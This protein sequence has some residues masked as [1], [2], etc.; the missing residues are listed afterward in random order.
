MIRHRRFAPA[1][2]HG[3]DSNKEKYDR[4]DGENLEQHGDLPCRSV[5]MVPQG[6]RLCSDNGHVH[7]N[8][9]F[10]VPVTQRRA[11]FISRSL[12][13]STLQD[14]QSWILR[15]TRIGSRA[16]AHIEN[17]APIGVNFAHEYTT[18]A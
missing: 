11:L 12:I 15:E 9:F 18:G 2:E 13:A 1:L 10:V 7:R 4:D 17:R 8:Q 16:L 5:P 6:F 3:Y 14:R